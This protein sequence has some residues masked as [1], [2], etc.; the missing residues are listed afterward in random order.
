MNAHCVCSFKK[1]ASPS[2]EINV[3]KTANY[4]FMALKLYQNL[5][6]EGGGGGELG[7]GRLSNH[8]MYRCSILYVRTRTVDNSS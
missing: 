3:R 5:K 6:L 4:K 8:R 7:V 1:D 2:G